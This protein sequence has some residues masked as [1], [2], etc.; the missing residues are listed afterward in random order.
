MYTHQMAA[1]LH[2]YSGCR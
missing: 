1:R 2:R